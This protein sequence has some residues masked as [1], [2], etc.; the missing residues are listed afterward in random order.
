MPLD[1]DNGLPG[2][3]LRL[4]REGSTEVSFTGHVD[5]C[6]A[7]ST[8]NLLLHQ[9][10]MTK[11]PHTVAEYIQYDDDEPFEPIKLSCAVDDLKTIE[12]EHGKL[13]AIVRYWTKYTLNGRP[14]IISFGLGRDVAVNSIIGLPTLKQ[15]QCDISLHRGVLIAHSLRLQFDL[16]FKRANVDVLKDKDFGSHQFVRPQSSLPALVTDFQNLNC[17]IT[18]GCNE[19]DRDTEDDISAG[20]LRRS[21]KLN[22]LH[23]SE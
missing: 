5:T 18:D 8:G 12:A 11:H 7:M 23:P 6:A 15:W 13:T 19:E 22:H 20:F 21:T 2:I 1:L 16:E 10:I 14:A 9:W 17:A 3:V 4:G